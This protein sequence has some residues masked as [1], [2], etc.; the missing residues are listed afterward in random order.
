MTQSGFS[1]RKVGLMSTSTE[2][3]SVPAPSEDQR[4]KAIA[5]P[6]QH[7]SAGT[8]ISIQKGDIFKGAGEEAVSKDEA[9]VLCAP[10][11][12]RDV[13]ILPDTASLYL[14]WSWYADRLT[15]T[16]GP[17]GWSLLPVTDQE[18]N[19]KAPV[20]K[21]N[22]LYREFVLRARGRFVATAIGECGYNPTN[23]RMTYGDAVEGAKSNALS[24]CCKVL[25]MAPEIY[26]EGWREDW[27]K[28]NAVCV[29]A[30]TWKGKQKLWRRKRGLPLKDEQGHANPPCPCEE[31]KGGKPSTALD[32]KPIIAPPQRKPKEIEAPPVQ[33]E[34]QTPEPP[35]KPTQKSTVTQQQIKAVQEWVKEFELTP[36]ILG[37]LIQGEIGRKPQS[38]KDLTTGEYQTLSH[39][40]AMLRTGAWSIADGR[41]QK[42][43]DEP[44]QQYPKEMPED[45]D[46]KF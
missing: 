33:Q 16:F 5:L 20:A 43:P 25:G 14:P 30:M 23:A 1:R 17:M 6:Q 35:A 4:G 22:V 26:S 31:C 7:P 44:T 11:D 40:F 37:A 3:S 12:S 29:W 39:A 8:I 13:R 18:N 2:L 27:I 24:R 10:V 38:A 34:A 36:E 28:E 21:D 32:G 41:F 46:P 45:A 19:P 9:K 42:P 15:R